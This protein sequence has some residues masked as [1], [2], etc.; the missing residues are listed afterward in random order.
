MKKLQLVVLLFALVFQSI[1]NNVKFKMKSPNKK[2]EVSLFQINGVVSYEVSF[3]GDRII[4]PSKLGIKFNDGIDFTSGLELRQIGKKRVKHNWSQ[5][6]GEV[7]N[8]VDNHNEYQ[9]K[10]SKDAKVVR[11]NFRIFDDGIGF[12]YEVGENSG[13]SEVQILDEVTEFNL[14]KDDEAWWI[15]AYQA[16]SYEHLYKKDPL[17]QITDSIHTPLTVELKNKKLIS[18]HEAALTDYASMVLV[19]NQKGGLE[20]DLAPWPDGVKVKTKAPFKS[21]WRTI[22]IGSNAGELMTSTLILN[23]NEPN[24]IDDCSWIKPGKYIGIWWEMHLKK[25]TWKQGVKHGANTKNV[26]RYIDFA[27]KYGFDGVLVEGWNYG[28][29]GKWYKDGSDFKFTKPVPDFDMNELSAYGKSKG[30]SIIGHHET[31]G[32]VANYLKQVDEAFIY[33][34]KH[35][36]KAIK[37]GHVGRYLNGIHTHYGQF[38]VEFYRDIVKRAADAK[39]MLDVHEPVKAT[40]IRRTWPNMMTREGARGMEFDAWSKDGGNPPNHVTILPFTRLLGGPMDYTPGIFDMTLPSRPKN[41]SNMTLAKQLAVY[42]LLYSPLHMAADLPENYEGN[43]AFQFILDVPTDWET[44]LV[45]N[46]EI[47][48]YATV[49]RKDRNSND[50]YLGCATNSQSREMNFNCSFL[51]K[52][53]KYMAYIYRDGNDAHWKNNPKSICIEKKAV[54]SKSELMFNLAEGGGIA[55]R[56]EKITN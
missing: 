51:D 18:I 45:P 4:S 9:Y 8:V 23:L 56:F 34:Q 5:P 32:D 15:P 50:W 42:V 46:A 16:N 17:V 24:K 39:I 6:W 3:A 37:T 40:G 33:S 11:L 25:S 27:S 20:C 28:W 43:P 10:I 7:K 29:N 48:Q 38:A 31:G 35:N 52:K 1:A 55:I 13:F 41:S 30:V 26:K 47:G 53:A 21:P 2:I 54:T 49:V 44:T 14:Q 22:Q 19:S 12:R 36:I